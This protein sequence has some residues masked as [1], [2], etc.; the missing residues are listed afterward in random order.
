MEATVQMFKDQSDMLSGCLSEGF[1]FVL[2]DT[3]PFA[4][5]EASSLKGHYGLHP[6]IQENLL[7]H[8]DYFAELAK[9]V[10]ERLQW[11]A[12]DMTPATPRPVTLLVI[13]LCRSGTHRSV[14]FGFLMNRYLKSL[15]IRTETIRLQ[16]TNPRICP[17]MKCAQCNALSPEL[18]TKLERN[19]SKNAKIWNRVM[20]ELG[21]GIE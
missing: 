17:W 19:L 1:P 12:A 15:N 5:P 14:A 21:M 10:L 16:S 11:A 20:S 2:C 7:Y 6:Q 3:R 4:D 18:E 9:I 13:C 8:Q